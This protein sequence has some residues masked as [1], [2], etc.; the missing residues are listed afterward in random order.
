MSAFAGRQRSTDRPRP[1]SGV[2]ADRQGD[3]ASFWPSQAQVDIVKRPLLAATLIVNGQISVLESN[4][5]E[6]L[7]VKSGGA[8][9][10]DPSEKSGKIRNCVSRRRGVWLSRSEEHTSELQSRF[11]ISY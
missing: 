10:I 3:A 2:G 6:I 4:L 9:A 8:D 7:A 11:G 5:A 1:L